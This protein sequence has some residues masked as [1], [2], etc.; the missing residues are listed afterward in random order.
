MVGNIA[1]SVPDAAPMVPGL[2]RQRLSLV[3]LIVGPSAQRIAISGGMEHNPASLSLVFR[4]ED[5][6]EVLTGTLNLDLPLLPMFQEPGH[7]PRA[8]PGGRPV[9]Y[10]V[11]AWTLEPNAA[12]LAF[13]GYLLA[14]A[15]NQNDEPLPEADGTEFP[16]FIVTVS[17]SDKDF[18]AQ[19]ERRMI[20]CLA[21]TPAFLFSR[22]GPRSASPRC[23][24]IRSPSLRAC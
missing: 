9:G 7:G 19:S 23:A 3:L 12:H 16:V 1:L 20:W 14:V 2:P 24:T 8:H 5:V 4:R 11:A 18:L 10:D 15:E 17:P 22:V 13:H 6:G 21:H